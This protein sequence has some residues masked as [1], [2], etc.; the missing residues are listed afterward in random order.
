MEVLDLFKL[1]TSKSASDLFIT[2]GAPPSLKVDGQVFPVKTDV[3]TPESSQQLVDSLMNDAQRQQFETDKEANFAVNPDGLGRFRVNV[4]RQQGQAGMVVRR[5]STHIPT[6]EELNLPPAILE[7]IAMTRR[8]LVLFVGGTG[9]GKSS[10]QAA[11]VGYRNHHTRGHIVTV[12]D[13]IEFVH[14]H[15]RCIV[16]QREI[17]VDTLSYQSALENAM[18]QAPDVIQIGEIRTPET[19]KQAIVFAETG[20]LCF[21][22]LHA[23]NTYQALERIV[24]LHR[25]PGD[26]GTLYMDLSMNLKAIISQRLVPRVTGSGFVPAIEVMLNSPLVSDLILKGQIDN[27][28]DAVEKSVDEGM[29][30]F[31]QSVFDLFEKGLISYENAMRNADSENNLRLKIKLEGKAAKGQKDLGSTFERVEF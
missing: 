10:T 15:D 30:S 1:M 3:L 29:I 7:K 6:F 20:H 8:G 14:T 13:P 12:E 17:G 2:V 22:T 9:T 28:R 26:S 23:N 19:M 4:F 16:T 25:R 31:D 24:N 27:I 18:R 5:I 11:M 21:A